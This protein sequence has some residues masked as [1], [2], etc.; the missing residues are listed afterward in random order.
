VIAKYLSN[1][2]LTV[3]MPIPYSRCTY[4]GVERVYMAPVIVDY[5]SIADHTFG[6]GAKGECQGQAT[7]PK[8]GNTEYITDCFD[9]FSHPAGS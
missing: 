3:K 8:S 7:P 9:D 6:E 4:R 1:D 2:D 5:G